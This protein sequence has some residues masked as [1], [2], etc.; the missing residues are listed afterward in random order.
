MNNYFDSIGL[1]IAIIVAIILCGVAIY[2]NLPKEEYVTIVYNGTAPDD[3]VLP[4]G[5][6]DID[7]MVVA[8]GP[9]RNVADIGDRIVSNDDIIFM[10]MT[11]GVGGGGASSP[12]GPND[13]T[14]VSE[15]RISF[16][17]PLDCKNPFIYAAGGGHKLPGDIVSVAHCDDKNIIYEEIMGEDGFSTYWRKVNSPDVSDVSPPGTNDPTNVSEDKISLPDCGKSYMTL[18]VPAFRGYKPVPGE[19][20][21]Y[22]ECW[23]TGIIYEEI[24]SDDGISTYWKKSELNNKFT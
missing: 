1:I 9:A 2:I 21:S 17:V 23:D 3:W 18:I 15:D 19:L 24:M 6:T 16:R 14:S 11:V 13:A 7:Y 22:A 20:I 5:V 4:K 12:P 8:G 10:N